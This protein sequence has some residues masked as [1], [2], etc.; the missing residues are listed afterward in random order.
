MTYVLYHHLGRR[1]FGESIPRI[2]GFVFTAASSLVP[3]I[4]IVFDIEAGHPIAAVF[5]YFRFGQ[6]LPSIY[7]ED[8]KDEVPRGKIGFVVYLNRSNRH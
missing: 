1:T 5:E 7:H 8:G 6:R 2:D 3:T 4:P